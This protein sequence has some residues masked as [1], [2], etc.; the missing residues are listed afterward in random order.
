MRM[1]SVPPAERSGDEQ[2]GRGDPREPFEE[3][4]LT[5]EESLIS[6]TG[7]GDSEDFQGSGA[8]GAAFF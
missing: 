1:N 3:P 4:V 7:N 6:I 2:P 8:S 5:K